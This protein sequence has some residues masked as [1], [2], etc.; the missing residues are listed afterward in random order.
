MDILGKTSGTP[1][2]PN[3]TSKKWECEVC[4]VNNDE[5]K[6]KCAACEAPKP[7]SKPPTTKPPISG[8]TFGNPSSSGA[9]WECS[10]CMVNNT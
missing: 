1:L 7:G 5:S 9:K 4:M 3:K 6:L 10:V 8:F 2:R